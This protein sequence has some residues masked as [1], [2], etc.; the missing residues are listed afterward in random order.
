M[1]REIEYRYG[2]DL[3]KVIELYREST[4]GERRP[5]LEMVDIRYSGLT[6]ARTGVAGFRPP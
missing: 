1:V 3:D 2:N 6:R 5:G 4:L